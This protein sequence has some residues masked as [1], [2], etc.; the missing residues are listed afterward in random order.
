MCI[1]PCSTV[2]SWASILCS[3]C[4]QQGSSCLPNE[5][6]SQLP[7][8]LLGNSVPCSLLCSCWDEDFLNL[9]AF[10]G[11]SPPYRGQVCVGTFQIK[12]VHLIQL[13][14]TSKLTSLILPD[15]GKQ[16]Q[17]SGAPEKQP[18][19]LGCGGSK[20][21]GVSSGSVL[22]AAVCKVGICWQLERQAWEEGLTPWELL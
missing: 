13:T 20:H 2:L 14:W 8:A 10:G 17:S 7:L 18:S 5:D 19:L 16:P 12:S 1:M 6:L 22:W 11:G 3:C 15:G 4:H 21:L 9:C